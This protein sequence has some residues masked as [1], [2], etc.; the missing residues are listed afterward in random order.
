MRTSNVLP[1]LAA[2]LAV[3]AVLPTAARG[4]QADPTETRTLA[5]TSDREAL[6]WPALAIP[7]DALGPADASGSRYAVATI[8]THHAAFPEWQAP[9][10]VTVR[11]RRGSFDVVGIERPAGS[12]TVRK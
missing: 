11:E 7:M 8:R 12:F 3:V 9:I 6:A 10:V 5:L 4:Q 1:T 2:A